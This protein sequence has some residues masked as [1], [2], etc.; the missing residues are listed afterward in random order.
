[1]ST[2]DERMRCLIWGGQ[3]LRDIAEGED[4]PLEHRQRAI[5]LQRSYPFETDLRL[6]VRSKANAMDGSLP[7]LAHMQHFE[8][9]ARESSIAREA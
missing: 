4:L 2:P 1:M 9:V 8:D 7:E 5:E 6:L 3:L